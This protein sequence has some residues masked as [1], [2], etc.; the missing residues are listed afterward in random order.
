MSSFITFG[1]VTTLRI[2]EN[3][4]FINCK[5]QL[6]CERL[7]A[8]IKV[9]VIALKHYKELAGMQCFTRADVERVTGNPDAANSLI[10]NY[11]KKG[12]IESVRRNLFVA[13]SLEAG[14]AVP[15][16][17]RIASSISDNSYITHHSAFEYYGC[18]NQVFYEVCISTDK[19]FATFEY[20]DITYRYVA[21]RASFGVD[22]KADGVRVTDMERTV[23]DAI[24]DFD[25]IAGFEELLNCLSL[26]PYLDED[27]LLSYLKQYDKQ[28][29]YQKTGYIL[30]HF[31]DELRLSDK[32]FSNCEHGFSKSVRYIWRGIQYQPNIFDNR[33]QMVVPK[34]PLGL[35]SQ[36]GDINAI[37]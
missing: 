33:W 23:L 27:K 30:N 26:I 32:F 21:P 17:Y 7:Y 19:R 14:L 3:H 35:L 12:F 6:L 10:Y 4:H 20:D 1:I 36:G 28:F 5:L 37:I 13:I 16:R 22:E 9:G 31:K 11:Q 15:N 25:K 34:Q 24:N 8:N 2:I 29:L 18:A